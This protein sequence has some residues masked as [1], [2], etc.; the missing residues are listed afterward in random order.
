MGLTQPCANRTKP[1]ELTWKFVLDPTQTFEFDLDWLRCLV[2]I[3][4]PPSTSWPTILTFRGHQVTIEGLQQKTTLFFKNKKVL[5]TAKSL[6][7]F[8]GFMAYMAVVAADVVV[9]LLVCPEVTLSSSQ[10][11]KIQEQTLLLLWLSL[12]LF[13]CCCTCSLIAVAVVVVSLL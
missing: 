10:E 5:C 2:P 11:V 7:H 4:L 13:G 1:T 3:H 9:L 8:K 12:T 6:V